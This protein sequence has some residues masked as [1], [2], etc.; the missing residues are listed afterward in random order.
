MNIDQVAPAKQSDFDAKLSMNEQFKNWIEQRRA[1]LERTRS[2]SELAP[3]VARM[4]ASGTVLCLPPDE[5]LRRRRHRC[6]R[7]RAQPRTE[8]PDERL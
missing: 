2:M 8:L 5:H 3:R 1:E 4:L 7:H 6:G